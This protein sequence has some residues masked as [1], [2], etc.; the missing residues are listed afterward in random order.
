MIVSPSLRNS[1][2]S[3]TIG[4]DEA[5][6]VTR[7]W[8]RDRSF[9]IQRSDIVSIET[10]RGLLMDRLILRTRSGDIVFYRFK[11]ADQTRSAMYRSSQVSAPA[12]SENSP[13][14]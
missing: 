3:L 10:K 2:G 7:R 11:G 8:F 5:V 6:F 1:I 12:S 14:A 4:D 9:R 13:S